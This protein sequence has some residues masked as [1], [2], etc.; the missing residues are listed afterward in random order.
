MVFPG[1]GSGIDAAILLWIFV[2]RCFSNSALMDHIL[3]IWRLLF[4]SG[5]VYFALIISCCKALA[6]HIHQLCNTDC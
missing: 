4:F 5:T 2:E 1:M 3:T 6:L